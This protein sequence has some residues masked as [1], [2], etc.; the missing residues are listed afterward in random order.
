MELN[1]A[2]LFEAVADAAGDREAVVCGKRRLSYATLEARANRLAHVLAAAGV[3]AGDAV[4]LWLGNGTEYL[5]GMLAAFKLRAVPVN[6]NRRYT[7]AEAGHLLADAGTVAVVHDRDLGPAADEAL[8]AVPVTLERGEAYESAL[9]AA[10]TRRPDGNG[11]SGD[12]RYLIYTGGTTGPPKG[13]VWRHE[14]AFFSAFGGGNLG[15]EPVE[16]PGELAARAAAGGGGRCLVGGPLGHAA[17]QWLAFATL[18]MGGTVLLLGGVA[19]SP[20]AVL[21][22]AAGERATTVVLVG[23]AMAWPV[24]DA[25][26]TAPG[27]W[28]LSALCTVLS[29]G[30][31]LAPATKAALVDLLAGAV[32]VDVLGASETGGEAYALEGPGAISPVGGRFQP[33]SRTAVLGDDLRPLA[34]GSASVGRVARRGR[35]PLGYHRD[36]ERT[37]AS[38]PTVDGER[39][40]LSG[41]LARVESDG[42]VVLL[43]RAETSIHTGG[44]KVHPEEVE[45]AVR[46]HPAVADAVVVGVPD[47][48][49]GE[50]VTAVV[51]S[52]DGCAAGLTLDALAEHCRTTLAGYKVPRAVV[53][54]DEVVRTAAGKPDYRWARARAGAASADGGVGGGR[55]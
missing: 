9:A 32:V 38:F 34:P 36:A 47:T 23:E 2:D 33:G 10:P 49:W 51:A 50:R 3:G 52:R 16:S 42:T 29:G 39:W 13:V 12:D 31:A 4:G 30:A 55:G 45:A 44:E 25:L 43:G 15:G 20:E 22:Q 40:A 19:A 54:V 37:A 27:R 53:L 41:D 21:D 8:R 18:F 35:V 24:V 26:A 46:A 7:A 1:L 48:R 6:V 28:D 17:G 5:E 11:R 14:D